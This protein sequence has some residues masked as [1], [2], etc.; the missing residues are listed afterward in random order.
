V[1]AAFAAVVCYPLTKVLWLAF[2]VMLRPVTEEELALGRED[3]RVVRGAPPR[4]ER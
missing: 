4:A 1:L 3:T 2:D